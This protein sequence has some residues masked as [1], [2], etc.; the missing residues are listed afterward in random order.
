[1]AA[2]LLQ[3]GRMS[4]FLR[5]V[6]YALR[7]ARRRPALTLLTVFTLAV[8][9]GGTSAIFSFANQLLLRP[10]PVAHADRLVRVFGTQGGRPY[11]VSS[12]ANLSD[13]AAQ[14]AEFEALAIHQQ[15]SSAYGLGDDTETAAVELVS[16]NYFAMLGV[17]AARGRVIG[18]T[19]DVPGGAQAV[20]VISDAWWRTRMG[21]REGVV[22]SLAYL[23]GAPFTVIG[24]APRTF[25]GSYDA[26][27]TDLWVPLMTYDVVRPRGLPITRRGWGWLS[28]T[29]RLAPGVTVGAAQTAVGRVARALTAE[30]PRENAS[31]AFSIVPAAALPE[32]MG[33]TVRRVLLFALAV[34]A[35]A[36]IAACANIANA[37]LATVFDRAR[38]I[39][40]RR[41]LGATRARI[42][43]QWLTES[44]VVTAVA[45]GVG[46]LGALWLQDA[47]RLVGP[48]AELASFAPGWTLD[49]RLVAF[50]AAVVG[51]VTVLFGGLPAWRAAT[52]DSTE[53][54]KTDG[55]TTTGGPRRTWAQG[56]LVVAQV[57]VS[58]A[59]VATSLLVTRSL[60]AGRAFDV[61]FD[62]DG[63]V[64]AEPNMANLGLDAERG[65]LYY[66]DTIGRVS[67]L[68][69]VRDVTL[70]AVVPLGSGDES[71]SVRI[72]GYDPPDGSGQV[73]VNN[74]IV[75]PNYFEAMR[76]PIRRGR[77]FVATDGLD[78][79]P[80]VAVVSDA[81]ARR[82]WPGR[83]P[84]GHTIRVRE[85]DVEVVGVAADVPYGAPGET[86]EPRLYLP[87]GPVYFAYGL[88]FHLR[89]DHFDQG[90]ARA[91]RREMRALD[92][93]VQV[94]A[95]LPYGELRMQSLYPTRVVGLV[96]TAFGAVAM[97][98][99][100]A[101]IY[102]VMTH[103][104]VARRREFAVRLA[105]GATPE[106]LARSV[107]RLGLV[108]G[109]SGTVAGIGA[110]VV[111]AQLL[112]GLLF[113]VS[114]ADV[115]SL[116]GSA[117]LLLAASA[118]TAYLPARRLTRVE[119][120][121]ALRS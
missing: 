107:L 34:A 97:L 66:R 101:G 15:T 80:V 5:D 119:P 88:S 4:G 38:E 50:A 82:Y 29:A 92:P 71:E 84:V 113:G 3:A 102:G 33:P 45:A 73:G 23:N 32:E 47:A 91:V 55:V 106:R 8:G 64:I 59:L 26:L 28:A 85:R 57:S 93:R 41:A 104:L 20:A 62:T 68:P 98:L 77:G 117:A 69:G 17:T 94:A 78:D 49:A 75:W 70:A 18:P 10:L 100:L 9:I 7:L 43:R 83:D 42:A 86:P 118:A 31:L 25:H 61:G 40:M 103:M 81:M 11:E 115:A 51:A 111:L 24:V 30:F 99:A 6:G 16:G 65:R 60:A 74:N 44:L 110:A 109:V 120:S 79:A 95:P 63:L 2:D 52:S 67:R 76:I 90:L 72:E 54:L 35:L 36:L 121:S 37:Q 12:Y 89:V 27:G 105:L 21:G 39:A 13:L 108:W 96:S 58:V 87:F 14:V 48:P 112:R 116:G 1:M 56:L 19:D 46:S 53:T 114:P 22:G